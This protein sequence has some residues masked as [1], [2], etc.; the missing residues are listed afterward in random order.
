MTWRPRSR[1]P[2]RRAGI[3]IS[4]PPPTLPPPQTPPPTAAAGPAKTA[5]AA[6]ARRHLYTAARTD[7][8]ASE[9][10]AGAVARAQRYL[11]A[12]ADGIFPEALS[13]AAMFREFAQRLP[14]AAL[15]ANMTEFGRTRF[16]TADEFEP[17]GYRMVIW[18][19][20]SLRVANKAQAL[21]YA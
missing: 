6:R 14:G 15:P 17:V 18:P 20:S 3:C 19:V 16:L 13:S 21:L 9:G 5:A 12:G 4:S 11:E 1:R 2:S 8:A 10:L 7:A